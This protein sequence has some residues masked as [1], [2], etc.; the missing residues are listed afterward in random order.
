MAKY[1]NATNCQ[2]EACDNTIY[3]TRDN[4]SYTFAETQ[5]PIG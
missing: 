5:F 4:T 1:P 3:F 2:N